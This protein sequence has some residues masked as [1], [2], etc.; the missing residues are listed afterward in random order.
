MTSRVNVQHG[1]TEY[2][3]CMCGCG[4]STER[5]FHPGCDAGFCSRLREAIRRGDRDAE[6]LYRLTFKNNR[7]E[8]YPEQHRQARLYYNL[9]GQTVMLA[10]D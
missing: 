1:S 4:R 6:S 5:R 3:T 8:T 9:Q 10:A 2:A 7:P